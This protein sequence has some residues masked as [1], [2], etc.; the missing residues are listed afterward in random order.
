[1]KAIILSAGQGRRLLPLTQDRPKALLP[2]SGKM[3]IE[4]QLD[5]LL[6]AG[7][8]EIVIISGFRADLIEALLADKYAKY[9]G[10]RTIY[11]P[12]YDITD[13]LVS[14]W[15]A[16]EVM[17]GDFLIIN[18]DTM[19]ER[20]L[21][22]VVLGS[23]PAPVTVC[24]DTKET[25]DDDDM[26]VQ[27]DG[28]RILNISKKIE[29]QNIDAESIGL[30]YFRNDGVQRFKHAVEESLKDPIALKQWYLSVVDKLADEGLVNACPIT[31]YR[32]CEIDYAEDLA[33]AIGVIDVNAEQAGAAAVGIAEFEAARPHIA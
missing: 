24:T 33:A 1:M 28:L 26:K 3:V 8:D 32:W 29:K 16:R 18:G 31:G 23:A 15:I 14:C 25:Y 11:N 30:L 10:V 13:N 4:W 17:D 6:A 5:I 20:G 9:P 2:V 22:D 21:L 27:T 12:F 19:F 7:V